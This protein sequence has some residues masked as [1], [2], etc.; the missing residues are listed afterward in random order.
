MNS[1][2]RTALDLS[3]RMTADVIRTGKT[4]R[5]EKDYCR[6]DGTHVPCALTVWPVRDHTG[7]VTGMAGIVRDATEQHRLQRE[8]LEVTDR[9]RRRIGQDLHDD[10]CQMLT[11]TTFAIG[12]LEERLA[13]TNLPAAGSA[14]EIGEMLRR[15]N[16][17]A[18]DIARGLYPAE[19]EIGGLTAAV[20]RL[21]GDITRAGKAHCEVQCDPAIEEPNHVYAL[22]IYRI[23]QEAVANALRHG[24]ATKIIIVLKQI[25]GQVWLEVANNGKDWPAEPAVS[26]GM[27]LNIMAYRARMIGGTM[28]IYRGTT[29]G[30]VVEL[31]FPAMRSSHEE[32]K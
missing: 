23:I 2:P 24:A 18:R 27:G 22:H 1:I 13:V 9:E 17:E 28:Q 3:R 10:L 4:A 29:G 8:I 32:K 14:H 20:R 15:A 31:S 6:K 25:D 26:A 16:G 11:A 5:Y 30:T 19:L 12:A 7:R 21:A